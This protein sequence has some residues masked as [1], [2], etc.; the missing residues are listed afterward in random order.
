MNVE[1]LREMEE[2]LVEMTLQ[3]LVKFTK[4]CICQ[5]MYSTQMAAVSPFDPNVVLD[6]IHT[7]YLRRGLEKH[8]DMAHESVVKNPNVCDAA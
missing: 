5:K 2:L 1:T 4:Q 7:E 8:Y 3:E 6:L